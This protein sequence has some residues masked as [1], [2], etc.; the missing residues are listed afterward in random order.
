LAET[1]GTARGTIDDVLWVIYEGAFII[2]T[3]FT[4]L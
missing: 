1:K 2:T 3:R 4:H